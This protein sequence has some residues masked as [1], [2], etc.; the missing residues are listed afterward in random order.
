MLFDESLN[1]E[2]QH[3]D[4]HVRIWDGGEVWTRYVALSFF[5]HATARDVAD[6]MISVLDGIGMKHFVQLSMDGPHV[7]LKIFDMLQKEVLGDVNKSL[8]IIGSC[9]LH[10]MHN[11]FWDGFKASGG[12]IEHALSNLYWLFKD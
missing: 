4:L 10:V 11:A 7:N 3:L 5:G 8:H 12:D 1:H 9:G 2:L 6:K